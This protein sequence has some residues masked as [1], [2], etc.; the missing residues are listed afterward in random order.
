[1]RERFDG[2]DPDDL[3]GQLFSDRVDRCEE[4][5]EKV[6]RNYEEQRRATPLLLCRKLPSDRRRLERVVVLA[7]SPR[8]QSCA[9]RNSADS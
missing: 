7:V 2:R 1:V 8:L 6:R 3:T 5:H 9:Y 4:M